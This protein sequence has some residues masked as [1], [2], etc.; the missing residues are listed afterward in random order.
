MKNLYTNQH[1]INSY[2][3][4]LFNTDISSGRNENQISNDIHK[5]EE[6]TEK[7][8]STLGK[9]IEGLCPTKNIVDNKYENDPNLTTLAVTAPHSYDVLGKDPSG[10]GENTACLFPENSLGPD[11]LFSSKKEAI[12]NLRDEGNTE[13]ADQKIVYR[14]ENGDLVEKFLIPKIIQERVVIDGFAVNLKILL[15]DSDPNSLSYEAFISGEKNTQNIN[16]VKLLSKMVE[17]AENILNKD[18]YIMED[19][20]SEILNNF[21]KRNK[22]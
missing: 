18:K 6:N 15:E 7:G 20:F 21:I 17:I 3:N 2:T 11:A 10:S 16:E 4:S 9:E 1:S 5:N 8:L 14:N 12:K 19:S 22:K 13:G